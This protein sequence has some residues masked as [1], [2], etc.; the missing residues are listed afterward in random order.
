[1][2]NEPKRE[3]LAVG[4]LEPWELNPRGRDLRGIPEF[5][6]QVEAEGGIKEDLH[7]FMRNSR[8]IIMQGH[9]RHA[10]ALRN[11]IAEL[12][13]KVY[14]MTEAEAFLHLLTLQNGCDPF[15]DR[16]LA[17]ASRTAVTLG[18]EKPM[19]VGAMHR[20]EATVQLYLDLGR[21]PHR[22][23]EM[24]YKRK[25]ALGTAERLLKLQELTSA[26]VVLET[27]VDLTNSITGD[28]MTEEQAR[29]FLENR[30]FI[31]AEQHK[32]WLK[33]MGDLAKTKHRVCDGFSFV[34]WEQR[35]QFVIEGAIPQTMYVRA[36]EHIEDRLLR[37]AG[38]PMTWGELAAALGVPVFVCPAPNADGKYLLLVRVSAVKDADSVAET[39]VLKGKVER[40]DENG[41][42]NPPLTPNQSEEGGGVGGG[43]EGGDVMEDVAFPMERWLRVLGKLLE[44]KDA[45][46]QD[47][48]WKPLVWHAWACAAEKLP[49]EIY[50][51]MMGEM[52]R[53]EVVNRRGLRWCLLGAL[54]CAMAEDETEAL[55]EVEERLRVA[56]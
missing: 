46:M 29:V 42:L 34:S 25:M 51:Q 2:K 4:L 37:D 14:E 54:A 45:V 36:D 26:E 18:I 49:E 50:A 28:P 11:G 10:V 13:C 1:M 56:D 3:C 30:F 21:L 52:N 48:L 35:D 41:N 31:P 38:K 33:M 44:R 53:D 22:A 20:S 12:W 24:V 16:E 17:A 39:K 23:V 32:R 55:E 7:V 9:R 19:L 8:A 40:H 5:A 27:L 47:G 43:D 6:V 15:D